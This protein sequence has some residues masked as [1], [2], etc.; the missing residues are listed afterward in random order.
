MGQGSS[1][2]RSKARGAGQ[3][4]AGVGSEDGVHEQQR[5]R[6]WAAQVKLYVLS[7]EPRVQV[8]S[9]HCSASGH[10][11]PT[12]HYISRGGEATGPEAWV[13]CETTD[14][15]LAP[16]HQQCRVLLSE[17]NDPARAVVWTRGSRMAGQGRAVRLSRANQPG[18]GSNGVNV[19]PI[20]SRAGRGNLLF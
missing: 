14:L 20:A 2:S 8:I 11:L 6:H 15:C 3:G 18:Q 4:R 13:C 7:T 12:R 17:P 5:V 10:N 9:G 16:S 19:L 1:T